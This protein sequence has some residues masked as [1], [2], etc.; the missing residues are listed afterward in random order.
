MTFEL[1]TIH[2]ESFIVVCNGYWLQEKKNIIIGGESKSNSKI[3][4]KT[5]TSRN[6]TGLS[7]ALTEAEELIEHSVLKN[8]SKLSQSTLSNYF[9]LQAKTIKLSQFILVLHN[10]FIHSFGPFGLSLY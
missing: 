3:R 4:E 5:C 9:S 10:T 2:R 7:Q 1:Q 8:S 6:E